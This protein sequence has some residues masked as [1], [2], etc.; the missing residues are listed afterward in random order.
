MG[1]YSLLKLSLGPQVRPRAED[2]T[3]QDVYEMWLMNTEGKR[4]LLD[5]SREMD[6]SPNIIREKFRE[7][8]FKQNSYST[9]EVFQ[10]NK[11]RAEQIMN[12]NIALKNNILHM[13][14]LGKG[15]PDISKELSLPQTVI[16]I[17]LNNNKSPRLPNSPI[18]TPSRSSHKGPFGVNQQKI[19][20]AL[21]LFRQGKSIN[22]IASM[23]GITNQNIEPWLIQVMTP[24]ER[25]EYR[26]RILKTRGPEFAETVKKIKE[27]Y[28]YN[29][30]LNRSQISKKLNIPLHV[31]K[32][33][34]E[35]FID[36]DKL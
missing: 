32:R 8:G 10:T 33:I 12:N 35:V 29:P 9:G 7:H 19:Q 5:I 23:T 21:E 31:V 17:I 14:S 4:S 28:E 27:T 30:K 26:E 25:K 6:I 3:Y 36:K 16:N 34:M 22:Y 11:Q 20:Q 1:W 24:Q 2:L 13:R 15:I 18:I